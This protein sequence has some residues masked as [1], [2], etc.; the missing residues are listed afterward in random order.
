MIKGYTEVLKAAQKSYIRQLER[1]SIDHV[2]RSTETTA[3]IFNLKQAVVFGMESRS[4]LRISPF[5]TYADAM[6]G[7]GPVMTVRY[8]NN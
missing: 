8:S 4:T 5:S 7:S 2:M 6:D 3:E 1:A